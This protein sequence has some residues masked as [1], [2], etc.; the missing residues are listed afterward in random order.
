MKLKFKYN[1]KTHLS[2][3]QPDESGVEIRASL[4]EEAK[5]RLRDLS[6]ISNLAVSRSRDWTLDEIP[7]IILS[8]IEP[9]IIVPR[10]PRKR[11]DQKTIEVDKFRRMNRTQGSLRQNT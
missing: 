9:L 1:R 5:Q 2:K 11:L 8:T 3:T 4:G 7:P 10:S 6:C